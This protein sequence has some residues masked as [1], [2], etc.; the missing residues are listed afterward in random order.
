MEIIEEELSFL[1]GDDI[2]DDDKYKIVLIVSSDDIKNRID[3]VLD[4]E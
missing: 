3:D 2:D 1:S 4:V